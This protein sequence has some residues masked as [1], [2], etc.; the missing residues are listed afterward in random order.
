MRIHRHKHKHE[1]KEE[2]EYKTVQE[3]WAVSIKKEEYDLLKEKSKSAEELEDKYL[4][5]G[6][7]FENFKKRTQKEKEDWA[8]YTGESF[9]LELLHIVDNFERAFQAADKTQDFKILHQGIEMIL[10]EI[11]A[12]LKEK[13]VQR[14][15]AVDNQFDP[16]KHEAI[17]HVACEEKEEDAVI[18]ELQAGYEMNGRVVRPAKVKVN[19]KSPQPTDEGA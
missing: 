8:K 19:K 11:H 5:L 14:I 7:E 17:E 16:H 12:F 18:E 2:T 13:G 1:K 10:K 9:I 3:P 15:E 6:A 4:R